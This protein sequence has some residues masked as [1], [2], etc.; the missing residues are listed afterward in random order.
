MRKTID[1]LIEPNCNLACK[2]CVHESGVNYKPID[3]DSMKKIV[4]NLKISGIKNIVFSA[5]EPFHNKNFIDLLHFCELMHMDIS[6]VSNGT[7]LNDEIIQQFPKKNVKSIAI[8]LEGFT[9]EINDDI[10]GSGTF[11]QSIR[12]IIKINELFRKHGMHSPLVVQTCINPYNIESICNSFDDFVQKNGV[13]VVSFCRIHPVGN[14]LEHPEYCMSQIEYMESVE[15]IL[16]SIHQKEKIRFRDVSIFELLYLNIRYDLELRAKPSKCTALEGHISILPNGSLCRCSL[17]VNKKI[18]DDNH[19]ILANDVNLQDLD[20]ED[21][22]YMYPYLKEGLCEECYF[23]DCCKPCLIDYGSDG[24]SKDILESC[25]NYYHKLRLV[26]S[27]ILNKK[28]QAFLN[29]SV[30]VTD[31]GNKI[32]LTDNE[33]KIMID[34]RMDSRI[35]S[36]SD[37]VL[38]SLIIHDM[39]RI[40]DTKGNLISVHINRL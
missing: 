22:S 2:H 18:I 16:Q 4:T 3:L 27:D 32:L 15:C 30:L 9:E 35:I 10:R 39:I 24:I 28:I 34:S 11:Q 13:E 37:S 21:I 25:W 36:C 26:Y 12:S 7:L 33:F 31:Y 17:L 5:L 23:K 19:F 14:A 1:W 8:S 40:S 38:W 20:I 6:F 29:D